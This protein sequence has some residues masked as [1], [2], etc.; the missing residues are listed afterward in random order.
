MDQWRLLSEFQIWV[1]IKIR[2]N[3]LTT[4]QDFT[5]QKHIE[6]NY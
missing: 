2:R 5:G 1:G 3:G 6:E 4:C